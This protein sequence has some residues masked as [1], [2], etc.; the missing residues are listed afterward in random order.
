MGCEDGKPQVEQVPALM[1]AQTQM[2][3]VASKERSISRDG[4]DMLV[5]GV[6]RQCG[7]GSPSDV[8]GLGG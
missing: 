6:V 1:V 3:K 2:R 7:G 4:V 5:E 8:Q